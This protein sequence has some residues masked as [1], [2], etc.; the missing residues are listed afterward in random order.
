MEERMEG[1]W[2]KAKGKAKEAAG[3]LTDDEELE[4]E[5]KKDQLKGDGK[6]AVGHVKEAGRSV[7]D[8]VEDAG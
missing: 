4:R 1:A 8:A 5:G 6:E 7:K 2:D 3:D